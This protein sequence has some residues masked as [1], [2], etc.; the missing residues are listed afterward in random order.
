[1]LE[2]FLDVLLIEEIPVENA[3]DTGIV[4]ATGAQIVRSQKAA[5][6][7]QTGKVLSC[8]TRFPW[9]GMMVDMPYKV[10]DVV[11]TNEFGRDYIVLNPE[12]EFKP[13]ATK[14]YLIHYADVQGRILA[15]T[16]GEGRGPFSK[17]DAEKLGAEWPLK[18]RGVF[19]DA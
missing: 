6:K 11:R 1:M 16:R 3:T 4:T 7:P 12:D 10:G 14:Y 15:G 13:D 17:E 8:D 19:V 9:Y 18:P 5:L 2:T